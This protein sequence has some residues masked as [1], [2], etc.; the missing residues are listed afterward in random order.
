MGYGAQGPATVIVFERKRKDKTQH[1]G[2]SGKNEPDALPV[3]DAVYSKM[4]HDPAAAFAAQVSPQPIGHDHE[5]SLRAGPDGD[6]CFFFDEQRTGD[7]EEIEGH[8][9]DDHGKHQERQPAAGV[10][11]TEQPKA[12]YPGEN[13]HQHYFFDTEPIEEKGNGQDE[14]GFGYLGDRSEQVGM[15]NGK[16][17]RI[18]PGKIADQGQAECVGDLQ[19]RTEEHGD[20]E[21]YGHFPLFEQHEGI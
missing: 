11:D 19:S 17:V 10:A 4:I 8:P 2:I 1:E 3:L 18:D 21:E 15:F 16:T 20:K 5:Q 6:G 7:I 9:V 12:E 13:A 14:K